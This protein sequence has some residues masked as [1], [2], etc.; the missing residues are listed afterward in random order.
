M[1]IAIRFSQNPILGF[2]LAT[3]LLSCGD[4]STSSL[5]A[6]PT[7][8]VRIAASGKQTGLGSTDQWAK[9][10][11]ETPRLTAAFTYD[12]FMDKTEVTQALF[13]S[14]SGRNPA[15]SN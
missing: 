14:L 5:D 4:P 13:N 2:L 9:K 6:A 3:L 12:F 1:K 11:E 7:G 15:T 10:E 8:M